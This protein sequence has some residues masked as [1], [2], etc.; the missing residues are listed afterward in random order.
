MLVKVHFLWPSSKPVNVEK[1]QE[2]GEVIAPSI[3]SM[4]TVLF[5]FELVL[6]LI[7]CSEFS[8]TDGPR[9]IL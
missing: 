4:Y 1:V 9:G 3:L 7:C 5:T 6:P 8:S 2:H